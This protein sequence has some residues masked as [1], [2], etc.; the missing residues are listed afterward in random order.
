MAA[1]SVARVWSVSQITVT[2]SDRPGDP[3]T[4]TLTS[5][6]RLSPS[7]ARV[8]RNGRRAFRHRPPRPARDTAAPTSPASVAATETRTTCRRP[9]RAAGEQISRFDLSDPHAPSLHSDRPPHPTKQA[10]RKRARRWFLAVGARD[11]YCELRGMGDKVYTRPGRS[12][13]DERRLTIEGARWPSGS[14]RCGT[15]RRPRACTRPPRRA[16]STRGPGC[17]SARRPRGG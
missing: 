5:P 7:P 16:R 11:E 1:S 13:T 9:A 14:Q 4:A 3:V 6:L 2:G 10:R 17:W 12:L 15:W 8:I